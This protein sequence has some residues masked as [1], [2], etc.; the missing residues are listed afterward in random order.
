MNVLFCSK[1]QNTRPKLPSSRLPTTHSAVPVKKKV[2]SK[3]SESSSDDYLI[4]SRT[5][6]LKSK[7][8]DVAGPSTAS[9]SSVPNFDC[10]VG[11]NLTDSDD[12][13]EFEAVNEPAVKPTAVNLSRN[14]NFNEDLEKAKKYLENF[15][16]NSTVKN[17]QN[18]DVT[19]LLAIGESTAANNIPPVKKRKTARAAESDSDWEDVIDAT[20][21]ESN[22]IITVGPTIAP[23]VD[24]TQEN[25]EASIKRKLNRQKKDAQAIMHKVHVLC[26]IGH[27]NYLNKCLNDIRLMQM[28]LS[29]MPSQDCYPKDRTNIDYFEQISKWYRSKMGLKS[30]KKNVTLKKLPPLAVSLALQIQSKTAICKKDYV[31]IFIILLRAIGI[32]C[33]LVVN[34]V[35]VP[36]RPAQSELCS[37]STKSIDKPNESSSSVAKKQGVIA[38]KKLATKPKERKMASTSTSDCRQNLSSLN[39]KNSPGT[40]GQR[41]STGSTSHNDSKS[42]KCP[43]PSTSTSNSLRSKLNATAAKI[44]NAEQ[45]RKSKTVQ[46][47][48]PFNKSKSKQL[49]MVSETSAK[50]SL[51]VISSPISRRTRAKSNDGKNTVR[52]PPMQQLDGGDDR[53]ATKRKAPNLS[54][55]KI[56]KTPPSTGDKR[57][58][59][60]G[61]DSDFEPSPKKVNKPAQLRV[62][63]NI[64]KGAKL[65][66][67]VLSSDDDNVAEPSKRESKRDAM[68]FW[69]EVFTEVEDKWI[70]IDLF[71]P[72][73]DCVDT[74]RVILVDSFRVFY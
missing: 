60:S 47:V 28:C 63:K 8:F 17:D 42:S 65:D 37:L 29:F 45:I 61:S 7:F 53:R 49:E 14:V 67:R 12:D 13:D 48:V 71:K 34:L 35:T 55:L 58:R 21:N 39:G 10:N 62:V 27:G 9:T 54:K 26:W 38:T 16:S 23:K 4:D 11:L 44:E 73:V 32:Q 46:P 24:R 70:A 3:D 25:I 57:S 19:K 52:K 43:E 20:A 22:M 18:L 59:T 33:R 41:Q 2:N 50:E 15:R 56:E 51:K 40:S 68:N 1:N 72:K 36:I 74:I 66:R 69:V 30:D 5:L 31:L 64:K 6:D